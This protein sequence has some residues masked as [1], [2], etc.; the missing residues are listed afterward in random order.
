MEKYNATYIA[1]HRKLPAQVIVK[2][3]WSGGMVAMILMSW[4][5]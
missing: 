1:L 2:H 5:R 3:T 4:G